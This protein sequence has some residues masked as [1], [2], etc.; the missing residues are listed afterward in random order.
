MPKE[1]GGLGFLSIR[2]LNEAYILKMV[3]AMIYQLSTL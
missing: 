2:V 3:W 1:S